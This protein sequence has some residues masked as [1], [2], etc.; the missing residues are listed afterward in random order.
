MTRFHRWNQVTT[1]ERLWAHIDRS[2]SGCWPCDLA[3]DAKGYCR[4]GVKYK[5]FLAHRLA[6]ISKNGPI[7][8]D[9]LVLHRCDNPACCRPSHLFLGSYQ[10]NVDDMIAKCR[11]RILIGEERFNAKLSE[12]MVRAIRKAK[13]IGI[14]DRELAKK[15]SVSEDTIRSSRRNWKH[16][17]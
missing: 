13:S 15:Y 5:K 4:L 9:V 17:R 16:V 7:P 12:K 14:T 2:G 1:E 6:W 10:D 8:D 3:P 11:M